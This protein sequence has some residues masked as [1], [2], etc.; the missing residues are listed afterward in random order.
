[1]K[2]SFFSC[3]LHVGFLRFAP[4]VSAALLAAQPLSAAP[5][6]KLNGDFP[7][8]TESTPV[9]MYKVSEFKISPDS[10][11][12]VYKANQDRSDSDELYSVPINGGTPVKLNGGL[13]AG[14]NVIYFKIAPDSSH[15]VYTADQDTTGVYEL[16]SVPISGGGTPVKLNA[17]LTAGGNIID[18]EITPDSSRVIYLADQDTDGVPELYS[19]PTVGGPIVKLNTT[20]PANR[21]VQNYKISPDSLNVV[22]SANQDDAN[23]V[24]L[25]SVPAD[26][27]LPPVKLNNPVAAGSYISR[28]Q[29]SEDSSRVVY[30]ADCNSDGFGEIYSV[31]ITGGTSVELNDP[32][33]EGRVVGYYRITPDS[34]R[35]VYT[36]APDSTYIYELYSVPIDGGTQVKLNDALP[37]NE[38]LSEFLISP[39]SSLV[40]YSTNNTTTN[41]GD[42]YSVPPTGGTPTKLSQTFQLVAYHSFADISPDSSFVV[43]KANDKELH[44]IPT[45]GGAA[46]ELAV[47]LAAEEYIGEC[48]I[49][50]DSSHV[51]CKTTTNLWGDGYGSLYVMPA[52]GGTPVKVNGNLPLRR[53]IKSYRIS[54]DSSHVVYRADEETI[55]LTEVFSRAIRTRWQSPGGNWTSPGNWNNGLPDPAAAAV[56]DATAAVTLPGGDLPAQAES[57]SLGGSPD[58]DSVLLLTGNATLGLGEGLFLQPGA[59]LR[60]DGQVLAPG[61]PLSIPAGAE[62]SANP[63]ERLRLA[64]GAVENA[65]LVSALGQPGLPA[66]LSFDAAFSNQYGSGYVTA[67]NA[68]L[69]F[70]TGLDNAGALLLTGES[71]QIFG[72]IDNAATGQIIVTAGATAVFQG[73]VANAGTVRVS[74]VGN[75]ASTAVFS[76]AFSG[77]GVAGGGNV[78]LE[79]DTRPG[80][81]PGTMAFGGNLSLGPFSSL[82]IEIAGTAPGQY[83]RLE[84]AGAIE[85]GG[86]LR[87]TLLGGF[88]P[89]PGDS[90]DIWDAASVTGTFSPVTLPALPWGLF[91]HN[92]ALNTTGLLSVGLAPRTW[93]E[94]SAAYGLARGP[95]DDDDADSIPNLLEYLHG[96]DP[97]SPDSGFSSLTLVRTPDGDDELSFLAAQPGGADLRLELET[98]TDLATWQPIATRTPEGIWS[99]PVP[100][101]ISPAAPGLSRITLLR[102]ADAPRRFY[103]LA[104]SIQSP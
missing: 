22:Y 1:M 80:F 40:I 20:L 46:V 43:C 47:P 96:L 42:L 90:F 82:E 70:S 44:S 57:L 77:H 62:I 38:S 10:S 29:I 83:D 32:L 87:V 24:E 74:S 21:F 8:P 3:R 23:T 73:D 11:L 27:G 101:A 19:V 54:P 17:S 26:G 93:A 75:L 89:Q 28:Y 78:F 12:V 99:G 36:A 5:V 68:T 104:V 35:V 14:A 102:P 71:N 2:H 103:R 69:R 33:I 65:G 91:W 52:A 41:I 94:F 53:L 85:L 72:N 86:A 84:V 37:A 15:V 25:Y 50:P 95:Q 61:H 67:N 18:F 30:R 97:T 98:S 34:S 66:E 64:T 49:S 6:V 63:G 4:A 51:V 39:D 92:E 76:G 79:G 55:Y 59:I 13:S 7:P 56:I 60:G 100:V 9:W 88:T 58:G 48:K 16:Y 45:A 31:P 81:S